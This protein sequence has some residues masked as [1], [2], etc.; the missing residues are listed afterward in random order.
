MILIIYNQLLI[1]KYNAFDF[2]NNT[3][4]GRKPRGP[5][6]RILIFCCLVLIN[7]AGFDL[8]ALNHLLK[9]K[10]YSKIG[11]LIIIFIPETSNL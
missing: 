11:I 3:P 1:I 8:Y 9:T 6:V 4:V 5:E 2:S 10:H 7:L